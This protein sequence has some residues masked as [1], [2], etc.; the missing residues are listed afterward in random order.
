L[1]KLRGF[2]E[3]FEYHFV[4]LGYV[5]KLPFKRYDRAY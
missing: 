3:S 5:A 2:G 4:Y 1:C